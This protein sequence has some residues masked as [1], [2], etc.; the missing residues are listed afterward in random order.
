E[1]KSSCQGLGLTFWVL[2]NPP[3]SLVFPVPG[4][5][6]GLCGD[7]RLA[8]QSSAGPEA[9][10]NGP[11]PKAQS[12]SQ[13][14]EPKVKAQGLEPR[15]QDPRQAPHPLSCYSFHSFP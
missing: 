6:A 15:A 7:R 9:K 11:K 5:G 10:Y 2:G 1:S 3:F 12:Q 14:P 13:S 8:A 4:T